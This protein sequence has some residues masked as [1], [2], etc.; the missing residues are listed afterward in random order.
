MAFDKNCFLQDILPDRP[1][2]G[3]GESV[4]NLNQPYLLVEDNKRVLLR[5]TNVF[6]TLE[7]RIYPHFD[8]YLD[9][10][11]LE[12]VVD[13]KSVYHLQKKTDAIMLVTS[14]TLYQVLYDADKDGFTVQ[15]TPIV[16]TGNIIRILDILSLDQN[17]QG[18]LIVLN[19]N[20]GIFTLL[21]IDMLEGKLE[22]EIELPFGSK[23]LQLIFVKKKF[24][25]QAILLD[26]D[27]SNNI[28]VY[29]AS[30]KLFSKKKAEVSDFMAV[31]LGQVSTNEYTIIELK[32]GRFISSS[33]DEQI[34]VNYVNASQQACLTLL[35]HDSEDDGRLKYWNQKIMESISPDSVLKP[36]YKCLTGNFVYRNPAD[37]IIWVAPHVTRLSYPPESIQEDAYYLYFPAPEA[38]FLKVH[39]E[40]GAIED[41]FYNLPDNLWPLPADMVPGFMTYDLYV[42]LT[43]PL[44]LPDKG[45]FIIP[46]VNL[47]QVSRGV[48]GPATYDH[49]PNTRFV[50]HPYFLEIYFGYEEEDDRF[51]H[52]PDEGYSYVLYDCYFTSPKAEAERL[53]TL[54]YF[55]GGFDYNGNSLRIGLPEF[56]KDTTVIQALALFQAIPFERAVVDNPPNFSFTQSSHT[57]KS[58]SA[59]THNDWSVSLSEHATLNIF[60]GYVSEHLGFTT[61]NGFSKTDDHSVSTAL[62]FGQTISQIDVLWGNSNSY[63]AWLY[64]VFISI[65]DFK[66][67][68]KV[69]DIPVVFP[70]TNKPITELVETTSNEILYFA[71]YEVGSLLTYMGASIPGFNESML[72]F[73]NIELDVTQD[74]G[75]STISFSQTLT[76]GKS[77]T[78]TSHISV[79]GGFAAGYSGKIFNGGVSLDFNYNFGNTSTTNIMTSTEL[80]INLHSGSVN[81]ALYS[82]HVTPLCYYSTIDGVLITKYR[83]KLTGFGWKEYFG[84]P[85]VKCMSLIPVSKNKVYT[86]LTRSIRYSPNASDKTKIDISVHLFNNALVKAVNVACEIFVGDKPVAS[87]NTLKISP[88]AFSIGKVLVD[89]MIATGRKVAILPKVDIIQNTFV[90]VKIT[91]D[92][93]ERIYWNMYPYSYLGKVM[94]DELNL[95][96][97]KQ[98]EDMG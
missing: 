72:L 62:S 56:Y 65:A 74:S 69:A 54:P 26:V 33:S 31:T 61:G 22:Q 4:F 91:H 39:E 48:T 95:S 76:D 25:F 44:Q 93:K 75:G 51:I 78:Y 34:L 43:A 40:T 18:N 90:S 79:N 10:L 53:A 85:M 28:T 92:D 49:P 67:P 46:N 17:T 29:S 14:H 42:S 24:A 70:V 66:E 63:G 35:Q 58:S 30:L 5:I 45:Q 23:E 7:S 9:D 2:V 80:S 77:E 8:V 82:Y 21:L 37:N 59:T 50:V 12:D 6:G 86:A 38:R 97:S 89:E 13:V 73:R 57:T 55:S 19:E 83:I 20:N 32:S 3:V 16:Y 27:K 84:N 94:K 11:K 52:N 98:E 47:V 87:G 71:D 36:E 81:D 60:G 41:T 88:N 96:S 15:V 68:V 64:P 1:P